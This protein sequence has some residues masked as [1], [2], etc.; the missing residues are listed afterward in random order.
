MHRHNGSKTNNAIDDPG[1]VLLRNQILHSNT[2][3]TPMENEELI[4]IT[5]EFKADA[6]ARYAQLRKHG[7]IHKVRLSSGV[8]AWLVVDYDLAREALAH[9]DL[10]KDPTPA[11]A[12]LAAAGYTINQ[13]GIGFGASMLESDPPAHARL[14]RLVSLAFTP[15]RTQ[16]M[17]PR[18]QE[19]ADGLI[20][21]FP[22]SGET[23]LVDSFTAPLPVTVIAELLGIPEQFRRDFRTWTSRVLDFA[24]PEQPQYLQSLLRL[25]R[26]LIEGKRRSPGDDLLS[27]LVAARDDDNGL[28]DAE[29]VG[30]AILLI[31]AGQDTTVN[32]LGN[33]LIALL[34]HPEQADLLRRNPEAIPGAVE[35]FLRYDTSV[36]HSTHRYVAA[37]VTLGDQHVE[38]GSV[39]VVALWSAGRDAPQSGGADPDVL[40][41][42]RPAPHHI[43]FGH[44]IHHCLGAPLA[45]L[46]ASIAMSTLL[47]RLPNL[48]LAVPV[49]T[50]DW[51]PGGMMRG[52]RTLPVRFSFVS[53]DQEAGY[54]G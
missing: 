50:I 38:R 19:I 36:E 31:V 18:I 4:E 6:P 27:A 10:R 41:V 15:R 34:Q 21:A 26:E 5:P 22:T 49:D 48:T 12:V 25:I 46:E 40:D 14:R 45:R 17:A 51:I 2:K 44:G 13:P 47:R 54:R 29:L 7:P 23:D 16:Q 52:P 8:V 39:V 32:L 37:D 43:A 20:A 9:P 33:A 24:A 3:G 11:Q 28:S 1:T 42:T 30:M 35:E 53:P